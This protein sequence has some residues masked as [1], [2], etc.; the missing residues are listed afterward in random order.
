MAPSVRARIEKRVMTSRIER[1]PL[2]CCNNTVKS[3]RELP[4]PRS[5]MAQSVHFCYISRSRDGSFTLSQKASADKPSERMPRSLF[6]QD[7][8]MIIPSP[9]TAA[10]YVGLPSPNLTP[11]SSQDRQALIRA[12]RSLNSAEVF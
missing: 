3:K 10:P 6:L 9:S 11:V 2:S 4:D 12:V 5:A 8:H 1:E 7:G